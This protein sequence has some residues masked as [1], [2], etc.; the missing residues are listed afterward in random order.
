MSG[1]PWTDGRSAIG[2]E[3]VSDVQRLRDAAQRE[4]DT[5]AGGRDRQEGMAA[6]H[7]AKPAAQPK[8]TVSTGTPKAGSSPR[9]SVCEQC[10]HR[11]RGLASGDCLGD[12]AV[13]R[14]RVQVVLQ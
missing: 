1:M 3:R 12:D 8:S 2:T 6:R 13:H 9:L 4:V 11:V 14:G 10:G 7:A 5:E